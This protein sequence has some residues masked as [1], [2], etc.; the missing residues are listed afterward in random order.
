MLSLTTA[1]NRCGFWNGNDSKRLQEPANEMTDVP[2]NTRKNEVRYPCGS[3]RGTGYDICLGVSYSDFCKYKS[4]CIDAFSR[5]LNVDSYQTLAANQYQVVQVLRVM[6]YW[7]WGQ[8]FSPPLVH[9]PW[10]RRSWSPPLLSRRM[11]LG[12]CKTVLYAFIK[13]LSKMMIFR[14]RTVVRLN[15]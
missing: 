8:R 6:L 1:T 5:L 7:S 3:W 9:Q 13:R 11:L 14:M 4:L 15:G 2:Q 10:W 12:I